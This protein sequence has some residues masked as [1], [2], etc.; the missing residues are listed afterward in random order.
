M[1]TIDLTPIA[2]RARAAGKDTAQFIHDCF[3]ESP[4]IAVTPSPAGPI[5]VPYPNIAMA[6][7][8]AGLALPGGQD[9]ATARAEQAADEATLAAFRA[10]LTERAA[11]RRISQA[12]ALFELLTAL[13][14]AY[15]LDAYAAMEGVLLQAQHT[16]GW[17]ANEI[18]ARREQMADFVFHTARAAM[19][20]FA[21]TAQA[22]APALLRVA[23][24]ISVVGLVILVVVI[25][26][27]SFGAGGAAAVGVFAAARVA[28][29][30][31]VVAALALA[32]LSN[33]IGVSDMTTKI[34]A[35][36]AELGHRAE[37]W[38]DIVCEAWRTAQGRLATLADLVRALHTTL[39]LNAEQIATAIDKQCGLSR[40]A[41]ADA[42]ILEFGRDAGL[43]ARALK[44]AHATP[45]DIATLLKAKL[46]TDAGTIAQALKDLGEGAGTIAAAL[47]AAGY[48]AVEAARALKDRLGLDAEAMARALL[49]VHYA[50]ADIVNALTGVCQMSH[51]NAIKIINSI[52]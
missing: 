1:A 12:E 14:E 2:Q 43:L 35:I 49:D 20:A 44:A 17:Q 19:L 32:F 29:R 6:R 11:F 7:H 9:A 22:L 5:P 37:D 36:G 39:W 10:A 40:D 13:R 26:I 47:K 8:P 50:I 18:G 16:F 24:V 25:A 42:I 41:I 51:A 23:A 38:A 34:V 4:T 30:A 52:R 3:E 28:G 15:G 31:V 33:Y 48:S 21:L 46:G 45:N 27:F